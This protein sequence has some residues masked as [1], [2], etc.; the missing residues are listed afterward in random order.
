MP[1]QPV[2][3]VRIAPGV[4]DAMIARAA[5]ERGESATVLKQDR[6]GEVRRVDLDGL[7]LI[8]KVWA[9]ADGK[10][11]MQTAI[12]S[13]PALRHWRGAARLERAGVRT[14]RCLAIVR[15]IEHGRPVE[16]LVMEFLPGETVIERVAQGGM[17][18]RREHALVRALA[19]L[20]ASMHARG[21]GN[22]DMKPSNLILL[23]GDETIAVI[24]ADGVDRRPRPIPR[25]CRVLMAEFLGVGV[26]PR[27]T[28][29]MRF[30]CALLPRSREARRRIWREAEALLR[31]H[32]DP[33]P[34]VRPLRAIDHP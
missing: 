10:R 7:P 30:L 18:S 32:G 25:T 8:V 34:R 17:D 29:R 27:R 6:G 33:T 21:V 24:D 12:G 1:A 26:M 15:T 2:R 22:R 23:E 14:A 28:L 13:T 19:S 31:R 5:H 16:V 20:V 3:I 11:R 4:N 9:I